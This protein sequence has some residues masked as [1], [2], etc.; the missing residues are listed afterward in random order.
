MLASLTDHDQTLLAKAFNSLVSLSCQDIAQRAPWAGRDVQ[1]VRLINRDFQYIFLA[2]R[3]CTHETSDAL[4]EGLR[5]ITSTF[6]D[7]LSMP[8]IQ[9]H[10]ARLYDCCG[11]S[12]DLSEYMKDLVGSSE[13]DLVEIVNMCLF[14]DSVPKR[15]P[16]LS[17]NTDPGITMRYLRRCRTDFSNLVSHCVHYLSLPNSPEMQLYL[18]NRYEI[19]IRCLRLTDCDKHVLREGLLTNYAGLLGREQKQLAEKI[20]GRLLRRR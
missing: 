5:M 6:P 16:Q 20:I 1:A 17:L 11:N 4:R 7:F 3:F 13:Y 19:V 9:R 14:T 15:L 18:L 10:F 2:C 8:I 12:R